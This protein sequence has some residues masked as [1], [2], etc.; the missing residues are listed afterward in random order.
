MLRLCIFVVLLDAMNLC[1]NLITQG[2]EDIAFTIL[3]T[4]PILNSDLSLGNMGNFFLKHCINKGTVLK[5]NAHLVLPKKSL[6]K[7]TKL[8]PKSF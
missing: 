5:K 2:Q 1:L 4:F 3:K 8:F 6:Y 7:I